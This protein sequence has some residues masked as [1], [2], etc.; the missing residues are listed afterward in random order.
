MAFF[1]LPWRSSGGQE[2]PPPTRRSRRAPPPES[3]DALRRRARHRLIGAAV[4]LALGVVGF[5]LLFDTQPRPGLVDVPITI[6]DRDHAPALVMPAAPAASASGSG[7]AKAGDKATNEAATAKLKDAESNNAKSTVA[8]LDAN[9]ELV[10]PKAPP[11]A[12]APSKPEKPEPAES[13]KPKE[14]A[15]RP[16]RKVSEPAAHTASAPPPGVSISPEKPASARARAAAD[17]ARARA[18]LNGR[19]APE[20]ATL[21]SAAGSATASANSKS[22]RYVVQVGAFADMDKAQEVRQKLEQSGMKTFVQTIDTSQGKRHRVRVGPFASRAD[23]DR[24]AGRVKTL[25]LPASVLTL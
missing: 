10:A 8:G 17:S 5:P 4:L 18:L 6:P 16:E 19:P 1:K 12:A 13:A 9:E 24:A 2:A 25:S 7:S 22:E 21:A 23:A 20:P 11:A 14:A 15:A 3:V